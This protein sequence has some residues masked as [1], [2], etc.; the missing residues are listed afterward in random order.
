MVVFIH[1][2]VTTSLTQ[3]WG[4]PPL[5]LPLRFHHQPLLRPTAGGTAPHLEAVIVQAVPAFLLW[6]A[7]RERQVTGREPGE[8]GRVLLALCDPHW[9][10]IWKVGL[11]ILQGPD[12]LQQ[13][14]SVKFSFC[15]QSPF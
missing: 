4:T 8:E 15:G 7:V 11:F 10:P 6:T 1:S 3:G 5:F 14:V 12:Q 13:H 2:S 9:V